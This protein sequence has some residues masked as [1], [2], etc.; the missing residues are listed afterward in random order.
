MLSITATQA[1]EPN[2][3]RST[4]K[5]VDNNGTDLVSTSYTDGLERNVQNQV[6]SLTQAIVSNTI[7][8]AVGRVDKVVLPYAHPFGQNAHT[9]LPP[10]ETGQSWVNEAIDY[11]NPKYTAPAVGTTPFSRTIY[12]DDP[13]GRP[14][15]KSMPGDTFAINGPFGQ[16]TTKSWYFGITGTSN[17]AAYFDDNGFVKAEH[18]PPD[19]PVGTQPQYSESILNIHVPNALNAIDQAIRK[20][21][22]M[23]VRDQNG[24]FSQ[25][26]TDLFGKTLRSWA[27]ANNFGSGDEVVTH[28]RYDVLGNVLEE[29][30][31]V[32]NNQLTSNTYEYNTVGQLLKRT[33][34]DKGTVEYTYNDAG[35][36]DYYT[37]EILR[38]EDAKIQTLYDCLGRPEL[39]QKA[40]TGDQEEPEPKKRTVFD[41]STRAREFLKNTS[42][43]DAT[44]D[45]FLNSLYNT[46]GRVVAE[47]SYA[48]DAGTSE[49]DAVN[50]VAE[51]YSYNDEGQIIWRYKSIPGLPRQAFK[52]EYD[53]QGK[54][55]KE[56]YYTGPCAIPA[57]AYMRE[58]KYDHLGRL[59]E[60]DYN[61]I[62][63]IGYQYDDLNKMETKQFYKANGTD[64]LEQVSYAYNLRG[65][66]AKIQDGA[67]NSTSDIFSET[68]RYNTSTY[69]NA[70]K[71]YNGNIAEIEYVMYKSAPGSTNPAPLV[72]TLGYRYDDI[73]RLTEVYDELDNEV[74]YNA[75][76]RYDLTGRITR[77]NEDISAAAWGEYHYAQASSK[78]LNIPTSPRQF[79]A[80]NQVN[81]FVYDNN[82]N[83]V[84]DRSKNMVLIY[85]WRNLPV[86]FRFYSS[87]PPAIKNWV[88]VKNTANFGNVIYLKRIKMLY[89]GAN[90][91]VLKEVFTNPSSTT[92][93]PAS[94]PGII[95]KNIAT[96]TTMTITANGDVVSS[97]S[98][99]QNSSE[100]PEDGDLCIRIGN[101]N[102]VVVG[103]KGVA[104]SGIGS[105]YALN[106]P[107]PKLGFAYQTNTVAGITNAAGDLY[108][109][110]KVYST[111]A[112][113]AGTGYVGNTSVYE[114]KS[115]NAQYEMKSYA[116]QGADVEGRVVVGNNT[117]NKQYYIKDHLGS[118]RQVIYETGAGNTAIAEGTWYQAYGKMR[119]LT[120]PAKGEKVTEKFT[121][122]EY[123][124]DENGSGIG[125]FYFGAR[126]YDA[127]VGLWASTDKMHQFFSS[128]AY[129]SNGREGNTN[130]IL[131]VDY[132]G[133]WGPI[134]HMLLSGGDFGVSMVDN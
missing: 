82:G 127:D 74:D 30:A 116:L 27:D 94:A 40:F 73:N 90:N 134:E 81:N 22:L 79:D 43:D 110:N 83:M 61:F 20:Y 50:K 2:F 59:I 85:D 131:F 19:F 122:K 71:Q 21:V 86:E 102:K 54:I 106:Y 62:K 49:S 48:E 25:T 75:S 120:E 118:T 104:I 13:L 96:N 53:F 38:S 132:D 8:D 113:V 70:P 7:Y 42:F 80:V 57:L 12:D 97:K 130:P 56:R 34:P 98:F 76:Y 68:V 95:F 108:V 3:V 41:V 36:V 32:D 52:Y 45:N 72:K 105:Q 124:E 103:N 65:M 133:N 91:R 14:R 15:E 31:P 101:V 69:A 1:Q 119:P 109:G 11:Y 107:N 92:T 23:V 35:Q 39:L 37:D 60:V 93:P 84:L 114:Y 17:P 16:H 55:I 100:L 115:A 18:L 112:Q 47:I 5:N 78:L 111:G 29:V 87:I 66:I 44:L 58:F 123:D 28:A 9:F 125:M 10:D 67:M 99:S 33:I 89:D 126:Y 46:R 121:G 129:A 63:T 6:K 4:V 117:N 24:H 51:C 26:I 77:K 128:Y 88:D 64:I